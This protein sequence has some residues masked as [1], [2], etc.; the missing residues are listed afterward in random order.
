MK[1]ML[2]SAIWFILLLSLLVRLPAHADPLKGITA[3]TLGVNIDKILAGAGV[4]EASIQNS[5][6][7]KLRNTGLVILP[8]FP[9]AGE[10]H[11][12]SCVTLSFGAEGMKVESNNIYCF[13]CR[14]DVYEYVLPL[15]PVA[16]LS[17]VLA[18]TWS[19]GSLGYFGTSRSEVVKT[20][21]DNLADSFCN[22]YLKANPKPSPVAPDPTTASPPVTPGNAFTLPAA[23]HT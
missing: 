5:V 4:D 15:R 13:N 12:K 17:F 6:E 18:T 10:P 3:I 11:A 14:V 19:D 21:L 9:K 7:V 23:P 2:W 22:D 20:S 8:R 16:A 1:N